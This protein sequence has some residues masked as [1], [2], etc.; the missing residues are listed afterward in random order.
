MTTPTFSFDAP[1]D[2]EALVGSIIKI[3]LKTWEKK[4]KEKLGSAG[5][6]PDEATIKATYASMTAE[7][8]LLSFATDGE[9]KEIPSGDNIQL[10]SLNQLTKDQ[11]KKLG[12]VLLQLEKDTEDKPGAKRPDVTITG[13]DGKKYPLEPKELAAYLQS[14]KDLPGYT[15]DDP[16]THVLKPVNEWVKEK[17]I[18]L[19]G[20]GTEFQNGDEKIL[21]ETSRGQSRCV[22]NGIVTK[23]LKGYY[24]GVFD[25][26]M[27]DGD[28]MDIYLTSKIYDDIATTKKPYDG[29]VFVMQ[30]MDKGKIDELK[31]GFAANVTE[32]RDMQASTWDKPEDFVTNNQGQYVQLT[33]AQYK[34]LKAAIAAKPAITLL[35][36]IEQEKAK[37]VAIPNVE[38]T[39]LPSTQ[40]VQTPVVDDP[41]RNPA[42]LTTPTPP[43]DVP[44]TA[45]DH[46]QLTLRGADV[47]VAAW[48]E[49]MNAYATKHNVAPIAVDGAWGT[50]T[51]KLF[52][53]LGGDVQ[54]VLNKLRTEDIKLHPEHFEVV[55]PDSTPASAR[56]RN[57]SQ[58]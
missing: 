54:S 42:V 23:P 38:A 40:P 56:N 11:A 12:A 14:V 32:F 22:G 41:N 33:Q 26:A 37:G 28:K 50:K 46:K 57:Q 27:G 43:T 36:F 49:A 25:T 24:G 53:A 13:A 39:V 17:N 15:T 4:D 31:V 18:G 7:Q 58:R 34:D 10:G 47:K 21:I 52:D 35:E 48:Q 20:S 30:Q 2:K 45:D 16:W 8:T 29:P 55:A 1:L 44:P 19:T 3:Q 9:K 5:A 51:N 6:K